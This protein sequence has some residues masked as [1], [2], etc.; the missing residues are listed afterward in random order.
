MFQ[1]SERQTPVWVALPQG[2]AKAFVK[3]KL[4]TRILSCRTGGWRED[5]AEEG[6]ECGYP[7]G[8]G[9]KPRPSKAIFNHFIRS[10]VFSCHVLC[11]A[12]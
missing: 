8:A 5:P 1:S 12:G 2:S 3:F 11:S 4:V 6:E 10:L 7:E 9:E